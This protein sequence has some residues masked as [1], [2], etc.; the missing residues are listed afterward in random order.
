[1]NI[2][3][4]D[5]GKSVFYLSRN[6]GF[7]QGKV[8]TRTLLQD[9]HVNYCISNP[10]LKGVTMNEEECVDVVFGTYERMFYYYKNKFLKLLNG[11][12]TPSHI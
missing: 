5:V 10:S 2:E 12:Q 6:L 8:E 9:N 7:T 11:D 1:M 3:V 4:F